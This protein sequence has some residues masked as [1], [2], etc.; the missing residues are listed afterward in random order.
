TVFEAADRPL[1]RWDFRT[2]WRELGARVGVIGSSD[3][4][5]QMPGVNDDVDLDGS[6][7]HGNE[8]GGYAVVL[9]R[10]RDRDSV[11]DALRQRASYA[12]SGVRAWLDFTVDGAPMGA[13]L[14]RAAPSVTAAIALRVGLTIARVELWG[15]KV[16][17]SG[18]WMRLVDDRPESETYA[19]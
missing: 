2:G 9:A 7:Y 12:T 6:S 15:A 5:E 14:A 10:G 4:H 17:A 19:S 13:E 3:N 11:F 1:G 18:D 8:P 16:G